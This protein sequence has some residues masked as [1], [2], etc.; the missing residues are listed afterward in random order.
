MLP[1]SQYGTSTC[2]ARRCRWQRPFRI[3]SYSAFHMQSWRFVDPDTNVK[4][5]SAA[6]TKRVLPCCL[7][8]PGPPG[9]GKTLVAKAVANESGANFIS[10][11]VCAAHPKPSPHRTC[12]H[13]RCGA[14]ARPRHSSCK[15]GNSIL[16]RSAHVDDVS[17]CMNPAL[18]SMLS[19]RAPSCSTNT[20]ARASEPYGSCSPA[21]AP[22]TPACCSSTSWT[23]WRQGGAQ[24]TTRRRRGA[25]L[26]SGVSGYSVRAQL[27][28]L[29][30]GWRRKR[31]AHCTPRPKTAR[32]GASR[33][34]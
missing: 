14:R 15:A 11:K 13:C 3:L 6:Q 31:S 30:R 25:A 8:S 23:P 32:P 24:K 21:P 4:V 26:G 10:I 22:R 5:W 12:K 34:S 2:T 18:N 33:H 1:Q 9:C 16:D 20:W 27:E 29:A 19:S 7:P 17:P 28:L